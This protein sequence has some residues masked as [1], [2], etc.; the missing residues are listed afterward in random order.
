[1]PRGGVVPDTKAGALFAPREFLR[2][3]YLLSTAPNAID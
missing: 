3:L 1:M 2:E